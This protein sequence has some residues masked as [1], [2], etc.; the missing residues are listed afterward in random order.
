MEDKI[1][2]VQLQIKRFE[3]WYSSS[4]YRDW[5]LR[6]NSKEMTLEMA[7]EYW[8]ENLMQEREAE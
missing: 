7:I 2:E 4:Q 8:V 5:F 6:Q 3:E 1:K